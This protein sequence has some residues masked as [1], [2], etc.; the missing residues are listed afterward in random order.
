MNRKRIFE[1]FIVVFVF[2]FLHVSTFTNEKF[3]DKLGAFTYIVLFIFVYIY[4]IFLE[5]YFDDIQKWV[6]N[7]TI[8]FALTVVV[9]VALWIGYF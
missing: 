2:L 8:C 1:L 9:L 3:N 7:I 4:A 6:R 5:R